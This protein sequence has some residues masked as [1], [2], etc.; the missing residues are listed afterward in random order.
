[1]SSS[2]LNKTGDT[3]YQPAAAASA[4]LHLPALHSGLSGAEFTPMIKAGRL[5]NMDGLM[6]IWGLISCRRPAA[7]RQSREANRGE[8]ELRREAAGLS[9]SFAAEV[10]SLMSSLAESQR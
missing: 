5:A 1:M 3:T 9:P 4:V 2:Y 7:C 8:A 10:G 6:E